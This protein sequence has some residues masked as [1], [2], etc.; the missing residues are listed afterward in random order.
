MTKRRK[1]KRNRKGR[2]VWC[3]IHGLAPRA[4]NRC[5][6]CER[7]AK[8]LSRVNKQTPKTDDLKEVDGSR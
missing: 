1:L 6:R 5:L 8:Q 2:L 7:D 3:E 4:G